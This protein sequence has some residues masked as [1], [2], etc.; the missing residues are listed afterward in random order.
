MFQSIVCV[1]YVYILLIYIYIYIY[2]YIYIY[3][4]IYIYMYIYIY[5]YWAFLIEEDKIK[6]FL[7]VLKSMFYEHY[8][9]PQVNN[10]GGIKRYFH[11]FPFQDCFNLHLILLLKEFLVLSGLLKPAFE[12]IARENS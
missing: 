5:I 4:Y 9:L 2:M 6:Y 11:T 1:T 3:V 8:I 10:I 12:K 7:L